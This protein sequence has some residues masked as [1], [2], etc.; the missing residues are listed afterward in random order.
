ME[1]SLGNLY[2]KVR[3]NRFLYSN[4]QCSKLKKKLTVIS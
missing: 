3:V 2:T 1:I 4:Q